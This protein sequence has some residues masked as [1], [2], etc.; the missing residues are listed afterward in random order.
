MAWGL[1]DGASQGIPG[2][3]GAGVCLKEDH[4]ISFKAA[5]GEGTNNWAELN[6]LWTLM[7]VAV[8]NKVDKVQFMADSKFVIDWLNG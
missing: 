8:E 1:S 2:M 4:S 5:L 7:K 6:A 3:S